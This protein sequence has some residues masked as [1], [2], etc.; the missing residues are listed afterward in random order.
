MLANQAT[1]WQRK[2]GRI[3]AR[4]DTELDRPGADPTD[5]VDRRDG[6]IRAVAQLPDRQRSAVVLRYFEDLGDDEIAQILGCRAV[7]VRGYLHR[8]L[9][10]LRVDAVPVF[11]PRS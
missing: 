5:A 10:T 1:S 3:E 6:L 4:P 7:T 9:K 8:A 11:A 2:W